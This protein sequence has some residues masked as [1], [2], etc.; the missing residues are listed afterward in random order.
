MLHQLSSKE[1]EWDVLQSAELLPTAT[2]F[3]LCE[4]SCTS[5]RK[6]RSVKK[7]RDMSGS[8]C[9]LLHGEKRLVLILG[10]SALR[11][12]GQVNIFS[13]KVSPTG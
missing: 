10:D 8:T 13:Q 5:R 12:G 4:L 6:M 3:D 2:G 9:T 11:G 7:S 1:T